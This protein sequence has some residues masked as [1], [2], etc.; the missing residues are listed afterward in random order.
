[1]NQAMYMDESTIHINHV[2]YFRYMKTKDMFFEN[3]KPVKLKQK[4]ILT[5]VCELE[6]IKTNQSIHKI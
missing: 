6:H 3:P 1:M 5:C 2:N 4:T